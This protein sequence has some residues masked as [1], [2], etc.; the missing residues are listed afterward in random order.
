MIAATKNKQPLL[1][2]KESYLLRGLFMK[3][4]NELGPGLKESIYGN[5]FEE[6]LKQERVP[7]KR[8]PSSEAGQSLVEAL[9]ALSIFVI[10]IAT[11]GFLVLDANVSSRQ[12]VERTQATL[13]AQE[14]LEAARS[15]RDADFDNLT[16]GSHG[17]ALSGNKW[18]FSGTSDTQDQFARTITVIDIDIDT[19]KV[20]GI[21]TWQFT[22]ARQNSVTL[23]DYLTDWNQTQGQA[24]ELTVDTS[25]AA[26]AGGNK[27]LQGITIQNTGSG[28]ITIDKMTVWWS[29]GQL[30]KQIRID[31][32]DVWIW[33]GVGTPDGRQP[34]GAELNIGDFTLAQGAGVKN[35]NRI[36]FN[37]TMAGAAFIIKFI[38]SDGS[39]KYVSVDFA[40]GGDDQEL[41][42]FEPN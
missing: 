24:G 40:G 27:R 6:L 20:D 13:L 38:M 15:I 30:V 5:A 35:I 37:G 23:T 34:S 18:T 22:E 36:G 28:S 12:G 32:A 16:A 26:L 9:I 2:E 41:V 31:G 39:T 14:G 25:N 11:I 29:N 4:Y 42:I 17:I 33:N 1:Y 10:G 19:K 3:I 7:Y 21:V 8:E